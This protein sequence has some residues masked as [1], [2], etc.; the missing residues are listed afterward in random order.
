MRIATLSVILLTLMVPPVKAEPGF[1]SHASIGEAV[2]R[3][4]ESE[5]RQR[6][7]NYQAEILPLDPRLRLPECG[8]PIEAFFPQGQRASGAWTVGVRCGGE[9]PWT[10]YSKAK[11]KAEIDVVVLRGPLRQG[12]VIGPADIAMT[13]KDL[14]ELSGS[15]LTAPDQAIGR[16]ARRGLPG[17]LVLSYEQLAAPKLVKRG[18]LV[19]IHAGS[20][21]Y[22][23]TMSGEALADGQQ[24]ERIR[25]RNAQ[26]GRVVQGTVAGP[27]KVIVGSP[28][29]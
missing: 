23:I 25:V 4:I 19:V 5:F 16:V 9:R 27:G 22:Q 13:R 21:G 11:I 7:Q 18:D 20:G 10:I 2:N 24:G 8:K 1:Q 14:S 26:S 28:A 6:G 29:R 15:Y 3:L 17:G 12:S